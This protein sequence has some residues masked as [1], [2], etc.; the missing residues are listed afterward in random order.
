MARYWISPDPENTDRLLTLA[1]MMGFE[2]IMVHSGVFMAV[3]PKKVSLFFL[4]PAY[5][6][7][8]LAM[9]S[10]VPGNSI[11]WLYFGVVLVRMRFAF[12]NPKGPELQAATTTSLCAVLIYFIL[13]VIFALG[14]EAIPRLGLTDTFLIESGYRAS[15]TTGGLFIDTPHVPMAMGVVYF[16]LLAFLEVLI[17][18]HISPPAKQGD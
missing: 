16:T 14:A 1:V 7:F 17:F 2:F 18:K 12:S 5:S 4:I 15:I 9:N 10:M 8:A 11:L 13:L 3:M 6:L